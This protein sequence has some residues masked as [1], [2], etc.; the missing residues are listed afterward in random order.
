MRAGSLPD[1]TRRNTCLAIGAGE[2]AVWTE[3]AK[4]WIQEQA[5]ID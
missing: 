4:L 1:D 2:P 5:E 3:L